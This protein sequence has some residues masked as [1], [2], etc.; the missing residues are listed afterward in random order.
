MKRFILILAIIYTSTLSLVGME[1][2]NTNT[3]N[4]K[5]TSNYKY[6][7]TECHF[8]CMHHDDIQKHKELHKQYANTFEYLKANGVNIINHQYKCPECKKAYKRFDPFI[9]HVDAC[10]RHEYQPIQ[11]APKPIPNVSHLVAMHAIDDTPM[12]QETNN[13]RKRTRSTPNLISNEEE[14][15]SDNDTDLDEENG[16]VNP[17]KKQ[18]ISAETSSTEPSSFESTPSINDSQMDQTLANTEASSNDLPGQNTELLIEALMNDNFDT[19]QPLLKDGANINEALVIA[20]T[21]DNEPIVN[22]LLQNGADLSK[23]F[24]ITAK[25][26]HQEVV[27]LLLQKGANLNKALLIAI[28]DNLFDIANWLLENGAD[29]NCKDTNNYTPLMAALVKYEESQKSSDIST[30]ETRKS[31]IWSLLKAGAKVNKTVVEWAKKAGLKQAAEL[32]KYCKVCKA[33]GTDQL[34]LLRCC[35][36][37]QVNYCSKQCQKID[38]KSHK[39]I[40]KKEDSTN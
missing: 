6:K 10:I 37:K 30:A 16:I 25:N 15:K 34:K 21:N 24:V 23:A 22:W 4:S 8:T 2:S 9:V 1:E 5:Q 7:C 20:V 11:I 3:P 39:L 13:T 38:W 31:F 17:I 32:L 40:C 27:Q 14:L 12:H 36:C 18:K 35:K 19:A 28:R 33:L 26:G 29:V